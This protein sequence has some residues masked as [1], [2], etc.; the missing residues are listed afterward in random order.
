MTKIRSPWGEIEVEI[1]SCATFNLR[2]DD[3]CC[4]C[5][6][7]VVRQVR[8]EA[9]KRDSRN[10]NNCHQ[11]VCFSFQSWF[12]SKLSR[13][14]S[15]TRYTKSN[16]PLFDIIQL[17]RL[18]S[19]RCFIHVT[20]SV[21]SSRPVVSVKHR[22]HIPPWHESRNSESGE[23]NPDE[24]FFSYT[25]GRLLFNEMVQLKEGQKRVSI[26]DLMNVAISALRTKKCTK[27]IKFA[28]IVL[29]SFSLPWTRGSKLLLVYTIPT[30]DQYTILLHPK[31][32]WCISLQSL[33]FLFPM[34][35]HTPAMRRIP[36]GRSIS[37]W[38]RS[39]R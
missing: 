31:W 26:E 12:I 7:G 18:V 16:N 24:H 13:F 8:L 15:Q 17:F 25:T 19:A 37:L 39:I 34:L 23:I 2:C 4:R 30:Q 10:G 36:S 32:P 6:H 27:M 22:S 35:L 28:E 11:Q 1:S 5:Y 9:L 38:S 21:E 3:R 14:L 20:L 29:Y 33:N